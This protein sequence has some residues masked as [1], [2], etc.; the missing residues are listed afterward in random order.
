MESKSLK[1]AKKYLGKT[2]NIKIDR[3]M[4]S[5]HPRISEL[6]YTSNYGYL[7]GVLAPDGDFLDA[8]L[9][10]VEKPV[11]EFKGIVIAVIHRLKDDDDKLVV[12]P[13]N[14]NM[15]DDEIKTAVEFQEKWIN[16]GYRIVR[17]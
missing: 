10:K 7:E 2:I 12:V 5:T 1:I 17:K 4:G 6:F 15:T 16:G 8:Y 14:E 3:P 11:S 13:G 9:L